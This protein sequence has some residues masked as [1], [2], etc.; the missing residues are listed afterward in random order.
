MGDYPERKGDSHFCLVPAGRLKGSKPYIAHRTDLCKCLS[1]RLLGVL[2]RSFL[3]PADVFLHPGMVLGHAR[4]AGTSPWTNHL[5]ES[6]YAGCIPVV[7][8]DEYEVAFWQELPWEKFS[9]KW[10]ESQICDDEDC[11]SSS[12]YKHLRDLAENQPEGLWQMKRELEIHSC[13]FNWHLGTFFNSILVAKVLNRSKLQPLPFAA[14]AFSE[15]PAETKALAPLERGRFGIRPSGTAH[16][17]QALRGG[18]QFQLVGSKSVLRGRHRLP[19][20]GFLR[21][22]SRVERGL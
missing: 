22:Q 14:A 13:F 6:F 17:L 11:L 12:L 10:P 2:F 9:I 8:S 18:E 21:A 19:Q 5:Y 3:C 7:L 16:A 1:F 4:S 15:P 20:L